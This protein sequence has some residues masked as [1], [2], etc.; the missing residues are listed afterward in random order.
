VLFALGFRPFFLLA[1]AAAVLLIAPWTL[2]YRGTFA[3]DT[4]YAALP[5]HAHEMIFGYATAVVAGF[6]LTA[7]RNWTG[8]ETAR[9][10]LLAA[11]V[12]LWLAG[13]AAPYLPQ[14][15]PGWAIAALDLLF[16]P[17]LAVIVAIPLLRAG[18][19]H[20]LIFVP[21]LLVFALANALVHAGQVSG[22]LA[23]ARSGLYLG[24]DVVVLLI[25]I[26]GGRV[27]PFFTERALP[28]ATPRRRAWLEPVA[29]GA[30]VALAL[31]RLLAAPA[32]L[33]GG[34]AG[35]AALAHALRLAGWYARGVGSLPLLWVLYL[36]YAWMVIGFALTALAALGLAPPFPALHALT[37]GAIGVV[38]LGMMARVSLGHTGRPLEPAAITVV[39]FALVNLSAA[40]RVLAPLA[41]P[42]RTADLVAASALL[43][44]LAFAMA[45]AA[46]AG[47]LVRPRADGQPG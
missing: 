41:F 24:V 21:I 3:F 19:R 1:L 11:L 42:I 34:I 47:I 12:L 45:F 46:H 35:A 15:L 27:L 20:N 30:V 36:G 9:G 13:R 8:R 38:T 6:L 22:A 23:T 29:L 26:I 14:V 32:A 33:L 28:E 43:W 44:V 40:L 16:L 39:A 2:A 31:A 4:Y 25:A 18:A 7:V 5:W 17:A 10:G 37:S